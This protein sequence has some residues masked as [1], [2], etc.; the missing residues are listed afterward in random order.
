LSE[1][2]HAVTG[3]LTVSAARAIEERV[4]RDQFRREWVIAIRIPDGVGSA[5]LIA[6][7]GERRIIGADRVGRGALSHWGH[8]LDDGLWTVFERNDALLAQKYGGDV[9]T[10]MRLLANG[11]RRAAAI[12]P[13]EVSLALRPERDSDDV[14]LR[15]RLDTLVTARFMPLASKARGGLPPAT[16][17]RVR[18]YIDSHLDKAIDVKS[19]AATAG[20]STYHF[21]R[22]FKQSQGTTPH[23]FVLERRLAK[24]RELMD[25]PDL[26]LSEIAVAAGFADQSHF[27]RR[28]REVLGIP[29]GQFRKSR[30]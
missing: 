26:S 22:A 14:R 8:R 6:V 9:W 30:T 28:F 16:L 19:L 1:H 2:A 4:F 18:D 23:G 15:P 24:A 25:R 3:A 27:T 20:L 7:D 21:A 29:P 5:M 10:Q 11:G 17:R 12:T 13:P